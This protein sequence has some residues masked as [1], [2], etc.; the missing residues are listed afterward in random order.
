MMRDAANQL[1]FAK[2]H[3]KDEGEGEE[4]SQSAAKELR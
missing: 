4:G 2:K 1:V 3:E